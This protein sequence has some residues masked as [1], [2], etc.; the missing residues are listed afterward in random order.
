MTLAE[1]DKL[2]KNAINR[3]DWETAAICSRAMCAIVPVWILLRLSPE[4][5]ARVETMTQSGAIKALNSI[6]AMA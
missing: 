5:R 2:Y 1:Q 4:A 6:A 3:E